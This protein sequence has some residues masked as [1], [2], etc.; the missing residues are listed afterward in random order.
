MA[1]IKLKRSIGDKLRIKGGKTI[2]I[3]ISNENEKLITCK[4]Q[5][6]EGTRKFKPNEIHSI[7]RNCL[8]SD[9]KYKKRGYGKL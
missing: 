5:S 7:Y 9:L 4:I 2:V 6:I 8:T 3:I 1:N